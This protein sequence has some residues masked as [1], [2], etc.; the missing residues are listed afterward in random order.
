[1]K[2]IKEVK[3]GIDSVAPILPLTFSLPPAALQR[4]AKSEMKESKRNEFT[5]KNKT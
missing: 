1:L 3:E 5:P 2:I 4:V